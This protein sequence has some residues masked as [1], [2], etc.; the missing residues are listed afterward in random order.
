MWFILILLVLVL[1]WALNK[2]VGKTYSN[3]MGKTKTTEMRDVI[4][5]T[6]TPKTSTIRKYRGKKIMKFT[7]VEIDKSKC[8]SLSGEVAYIALHRS[9]RIGAYSQ[10]DSLLGLLNANSTTMYHH[11]LDNDGRLFA[12][13]DLRFYSADGI[14]S[15][16]YYVHA[17]VPVLFNP[18][19]L[20]T[21]KSYALCEKM[22]RE[23]DRKK[24]NSTLT[25]ADE[26]E[27]TR[28]YNTILLIY[29]QFEKYLEKP[30]FQLGFVP[31][32]TKNLEQQKKW[33]YLLELDSCSLIINKLS[34]SYLA[35]TLK[36]IERAKKELGVG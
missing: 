34:P 2:Y 11:V 27:L 20:E 14:H 25:L 13:G 31:S 24:L 7:L 5:K 15:D 32:L 12:W 9:D 33:Q 22:V 29:E 19:E 10:N 1:F 4:K 8:N 30:S 21:L 35:T 28:K 17:Y 18:K 36:R 3:E 16:S 6:A 26:M 23:L